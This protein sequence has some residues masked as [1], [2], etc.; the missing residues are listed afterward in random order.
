MDYSVDIKQLAIQDVKKLDT[1]LQMPHNRKQIV[2]R[3][4]TAIVDTN[5]GYL[6]HLIVIL[7]FCLV[8]VQT[9]AKIENMLP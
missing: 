5:K 7:G 9:R 4:G 3:R 8:A 6:L 1:Y 2:R